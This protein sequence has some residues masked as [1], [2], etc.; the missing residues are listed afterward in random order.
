MRFLITLL[1]F[2]AVPCPVLGNWVPRRDLIY[3]QH[4]GSALTAGMATE[5]TGISPRAC[6]WMLHGGE[7]GS[8][9]RY[10]IEDNLWEPRP[11]IPG[12]VGPGGALVYVPDPSA[13][14]ENGWVFAFR[15]GSSAG[16][17]VYLPQANAWYPITGDDL[18]EGVT[19]GGALCYGGTC[20]INGVCHAVVYALTGQEHRDPDT[21][22]FWGHF[23]RYVFKLV[24]YDGPT[25]GRWEKLTDI[26]GAVEAGGAL[27]WCP[28]AN[29]APPPPN[30]YVL[31]L[32]GGG[33]NAIWRFDPS[34]PG[35]PWVNEATFD[36][37]AQ[38]G[39]AMASMPDGGTVVFVHGGAGYAFSAHLAGGS[40]VEQLG[41]TPEPQ[42]DGAALAQ[43]GWSPYGEF[44]PQAGPPPQW[45][46]FRRYDIAGSSG[47][48]GRG[49][50]TG[51]L[52]QVRVASDRDRHVFEVRNAASTVKLTVVNAA[53]TV[54]GR[55]R[56]STASGGASLTWEHGSSAVGVYLYSISGPAGTATGKLTVVR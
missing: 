4:E 19:A 15:G 5:P 9:E 35:L 53:G 39:A 16:F 43:Y 46:H 20:D 51:H 21:D 40:I 36:P 49:S 29:P 11:D 42:N 56:T 48:Q 32:R 10:D 26:P 24:P 13:W 8:F 55:T 17:F 34:T 3:N 14:P 50:A 22:Q 31:A 54:I 6:I 52:M 37:P 45:R 12:S 41:P 27:A 44:G 30:G 18:P 38:A 7:A 33:D 25:T 28:E 1:L 2:A 23:W 47:G